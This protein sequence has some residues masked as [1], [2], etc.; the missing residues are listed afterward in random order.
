MHAVFLLNLF[1]T[2]YRATGIKFAI[3]RSFIGYKALNGDVIDTSRHILKGL[4]QIE[5]G[6]ITFNVVVLYRVVS[7]RTRD[8]SPARNSLV[9]G[10]E[11]LEVGILDE[12]G[13][14][15]SLR[16]PT[17]RNMLNHSGMCNTSK[18]VNHF[19]GSGLIFVSGLPIAHEVINC[20][21]SV[22]EASL[23]EVAA[24]SL[25]FFDVAP[26]ID[27]ILDGLLSSVESSLQNS[28]SI[29]ALFCCSGLAET[30]DCISS[31]KSIG[32]VGQNFSVSIVVS[33]VASFLS[34]LNLIHED[35]HLGNQVACATIVVDT[36]VV[37][38]NPVSSGV[39]CLQ[40]EGHSPYALRT[41]EGY[42][43][44]LGII[45]AGSNLLE[46]LFASIGGNEELNTSNG[47]GEV[48]TLLY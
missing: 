13:D 4:T 3:L 46:Y 28:G 47:V 10:A 27:I 29:F 20:V 6:V 12:E 5:G 16:N 11:G 18:S 24:Q 23:H 15:R 21:S 42:A 41:C 35:K 43:E 9:V 7:D 45:V 39:L 48:A 25:S 44:V 2:G 22:S 31:I 26:Q 40:T 17:G 14:V 36:E 38:C 19:F 32:V 8:N 37:S 1:E 34:S 30:Y 33:C